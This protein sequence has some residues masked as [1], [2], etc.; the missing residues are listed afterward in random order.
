MSLET[1]LRD[2]LKQEFDRVPEHTPGVLAAVPAGTRNTGRRLRGPLLAGGVAILVVLLGLS[3]RVLLTADAPATSPPSSSTPTDLL[4]ESNASGIAWTVWERSAEALV[5]SGPGGFVRAASSSPDRARV[6]YS[7]DGQTWEATTFDPAPPV[8]VGRLLATQ[9]VWMLASEESNGSL[10]A[11][12]S[13]DGRH[14]TRAEWPQQLEGAVTGIEASDL[15]FLALSRSGSG[16]AMWTS[17]TGLGWEPWDTVEVDNESSLLGIPGGWAVLGE[18]GSKTQSVS[19]STDGRTWSTSELAIPPGSAPADTYWI[20]ALSAGRA[21]DRWVAVGSVVSASA[22][23]ALHTW[24]SDDGSTWHWQGIP[25]FGANPAFAV[26]GTVAFDDGLVLIAPALVPTEKSDGWITGS[27]TASATGQ[28]FSSTDGL[29]W[30]VDSS[31]KTPI[32]DIAV[33]TL[34]TGSLAGVAVGLG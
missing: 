34:D 15:G 12:L 2:H 29:V 24:T 1:R 30:K 31:P 21:G 5:A 10:N 7:V 16:L 4:V 13:S 11:Y 17:E 26:V 22:P 19:V 27:G 8:K 18:W 9:D 6:E 3:S 33:R 32:V 20:S 25:P 23:P 14:W 28:I